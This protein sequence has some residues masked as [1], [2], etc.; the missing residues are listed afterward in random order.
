VPCPP[1][2]VTGEAA[3]PNAASTAAGGNTLAAGL[4]TTG[5]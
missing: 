4:S 2:S 1:G 5:A 3:R